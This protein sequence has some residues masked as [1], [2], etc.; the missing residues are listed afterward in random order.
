MYSFDQ[1]RKGGGEG[2]NESPQMTENHQTRS[3]PKG[4]WLLRCPESL[5]LH[6]KQN[7]FP[8][9]S[10][11][12]QRL[13]PQMRPSP[14]GV[15][16]LWKLFLVAER[17][18]WPVTAGCRLCTSAIGRQDPCPFP[19]AW[20]GFPVHPTACEWVISFSNRDHVT[21]I[22]GRIHRGRSESGKV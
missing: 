9:L 3:R 7:L 10:T 4:F 20:H 6:A 15:E 18:A 13:R 1:W 17:G 8:Q 2:L 22:P 14:K 5:E 11:W 12:S 19:E 21:K 16:L